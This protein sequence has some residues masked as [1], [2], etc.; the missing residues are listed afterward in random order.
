MIISNYGQFGLIGC[1]EFAALKDRL[2]LLLAQA[3]ELGLS[4][5]GYLAAKAYY[6]QHSGI[7]NTDVILL[8]SYC[9]TAVSEIQARITKLKIEIDDAGAI[10]IAGDAPE[11][12]APPADDFTST[13]KWVAGAVAAGAVVW[14]TAPLVISGIAKAIVKKR[15]GAR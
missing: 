12:E 15:K 1:G 5:P 13:I 11:I 14:L 7:L 3:E 9:T 8:G 2:V 6:A 4:G 10:P